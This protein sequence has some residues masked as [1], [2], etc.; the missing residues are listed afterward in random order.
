MNQGTDRLRAAIRGSHTR[1]SRATLL[2]NRLPVMELPIIGGSVICDSSAS[3]RRRCENVT[4]QGRA[5]LVPETG[6]DALFP[7]VN[8]IQIFTG[9]QFR[10]ADPARNLE[11]DE[12]LV[13]LGIF[14]VDKPESSYDDGMVTITASG[15]DRASRASNNRLKKPYVVAGGI[16]YWIGI[17]GLIKFADPRATFNFNQVSYRT[18]QLVLDIGADPWEE[19]QKM[20]SAVGHDLYYDINGVCQLQPTSDPSTSPVA[21]EY[22]EGEDNM[23]LSAKKTLDGSY[24]YNHVVV[25]AYSSTGEDGPILAE[26][27]DDDPSSPTYAGDPV[28]SS[29]YGDVPYFITSSMVA[30]RA[31]GQAYADSTLVRILGAGELLECTAMVNPLH[32]AG[33]VVAISWSPLRINGKSAM[34]QFEIPLS[35]DSDMS[36]TTKRR[37]VR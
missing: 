36:F 12:D 33:D 29:D 21:W 4:I 31:Q 14:R 11:A 23:L 16:P 17:G 28:G 30:T 24:G 18:P 3:I 2:S 5:D 25:R 26:A 37:Q 20:A 27:W 7:N 1:V 22:L 9:V 34:E 15:L 6:N 19:A 8:E 32:E 10:P 13:S 35:S